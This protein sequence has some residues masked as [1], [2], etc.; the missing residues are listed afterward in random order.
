MIAHQLAVLILSGM[1]VESLA[2]LLRCSEVDTL[3]GTRLIA[4]ES[5][6]QKYIDRILGQWLIL[7]PSAMGLIVTSLLQT[8]QGPIHFIIIQESRNF[9]EWYE[10]CCLAEGLGILD[11]SECCD[12]VTH[13]RPLAT[14][15]ESL[16]HLA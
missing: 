4:I 10:S 12:P 16:S 14:L 9:V 2:A 6:G 11:F 8:L 15:C 1:P 7:W 3:S 13:I 5:P